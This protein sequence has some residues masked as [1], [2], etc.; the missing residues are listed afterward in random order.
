M[1]EKYELPWH[2]IIRSDGKIAL[3]GE[4]KALQIELL[5]RE[6]VKVSNDGKV[7]KAFFV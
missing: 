2:R 4:G 3:E 5:R 7:D 6:R 1:S